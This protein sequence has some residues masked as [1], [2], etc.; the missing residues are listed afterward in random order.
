MSLKSFHIAFIIASIFLAAFFTAW[1]FQEFSANNRPAF[2][3]AMFGGLSAGVSLIFYLFWFVKKLRNSHLTWA[4]VFFGF[5]LPKQIW[6]CAVCVGDTNTPQVQSANA[7]V[8]FLLVVISIVLTA[9]GSLFLVWRKR[10]IAISSN[11]S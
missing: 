1:S 6:A 5:A 9:I 4:F 2:L 3:V 8:L 11:Q 10:A 7:A